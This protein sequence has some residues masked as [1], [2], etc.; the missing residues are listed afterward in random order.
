MIDCCKTRFCLG[1][2]GFPVISIIRLFQAVI[3]E[4]ILFK[5]PERVQMKPPN[6]KMFK[7]LN[8]PNNHSYMSFVSLRKQ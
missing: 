8:V 6:L 7:I 3:S 2:F 5:I 4:L 1:R